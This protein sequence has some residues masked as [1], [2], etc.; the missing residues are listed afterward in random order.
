MFCERCLKFQ[1][2]AGL[3]LA[4]VPDETADSPDSAAILLSQEANFFNNI[5]ELKVA[6]TSSCSLCR[7]VS[8]SV[9]AHEVSDFPSSTSTVVALSLK[10]GRYSLRARFEDHSRHL[11]APVVKSTKSIAIY[12]PDLSK[13][14]D[15]LVTLDRC[16]ALENESTGS[17]ASFE[18][19]RYWVKDCLMNHPKCMKTMEG[20]LPDRVIDVGPPDGS[21]VPRLVETAELSHALTKSEL[22]YVALSHCWGPKQ[23]ITT[24]TATFEERKRGIAMEDLSQTFRDAIAATRKLER[25]FIW[26]DSLCIIQD[27][28]E[29]WEEQSVQMCTIYQRAV[30][31][32]MA[33][34]ASGSDEG[35]FVNRDGLAQFPFRLQ[36]KKGDGE[37][38]VIS[39]C[40]LPLTRMSAN[41]S[42]S[43][44]LYSRA[45]VL[46]EQAISRAR[47]IY[48]GEQVYWECQSSRG[49]ERCPN[50]GSEI[51]GLTDFTRAITTTNDPFTASRTNDA[52][53]FVEDLH[54]QWCALLENY[55]QRGITLTTDR[56]IAVDGLAQAI[57][58]RTSNRY[59]AGLWRDQLVMGLMWYIPWDAG[60]TERW[61]AISR[62]STTHMPS[63]HAKPLA[64]SWSWASVTYPVEWPWS[65]ATKKSFM[66]L[67]TVCE[68]MDAD[69]QGTPFR[70]T[71][72]VVVRGMIQRLWVD[73]C[74][75][76]LYF[77]GHENKDPKIKK[78]GIV[79]RN[80][81][82]E[83]AWA[84]CRASTKEPSSPNSFY[85]FP[86]AF[87]P[88]ELLDRTQEVTFVALGEVPA[89][90]NSGISP[91]LSR[92]TIFALALQPTG[93]NNEYRR[94]GFSQWKNC[95][96]YGY[97][98][99][100]DNY[101]PDYWDRLKTAYSIDG[102]R[103][104]VRQLL[105]VCVV[106][107]FGKLLRQPVMQQPRDG[108]VWFRE[109]VSG[110][111]MWR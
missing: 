90:G 69:V 93:R 91:H 62:K 40:F 66:N 19:V 103:V 58:E 60:S 20:W 44:P 8:K 33:A 18:M 108:L 100:G 79:N 47:L 42:F 95:S 85:S 68:I 25:R 101:T 57:R 43:L 56:L 96:W 98:C 94:V 104:L 41:L 45:W 84:V 46:Q 75:P 15:L 97:Y 102:W 21:L 99:V 111:Q 9:D 26:I 22:N 107:I 55:M 28:K 6:A 78:L 27:S 92:P 77:L 14:E 83:W 17:D 71:G 16:A 35:C 110:K 63:R 37:G 49:S 7:C 73:P 48:F 24:R 4:Q 81:R 1:D 5:Q 61:E 32:I 13:V 70:Q 31:T 65:H 82:S 87:Y 109:L 86:M 38:D 2:D 52:K 51:S 12:A 74:Y 80:Y 34:H 89:E 23:I 67:K 59:L 29:D 10:Q 50:G 30:F 36:F 76:S 64:P 53:G 88:D 3:K 105:E 11:E 106:L 72:T 54:S 39:A